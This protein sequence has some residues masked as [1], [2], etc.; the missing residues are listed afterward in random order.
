[1]KYFYQSFLVVG[2]LIFAV[3]PT[4]AQNFWQSVSIPNVNSNVNALVFNAQGHIFVATNGNGIFR[5]TDEG[6]TWAELNTGDTR[7]SFY[8]LGISRNGTL[9]AGSYLGTVLRSTDNGD[10]WTS[11]Q[12]ISTVEG[13]DSSARSIVTSFAFDEEGRVYAAT[14][15]HGIFMSL[16]NGNT[17][18]LLQTNFSY[19]FPMAFDER[20]NLMVGSYGGGIYMSTNR[21]KRWSYTGFSVFLFYQIRIR[22]YVRIGAVDVL[23][24]VIYT[25]S[26][27]G[28]TTIVDSAQQGTSVVGLDTNIT[29]MYSYVYEQLPM[30]V[31][32]FA[33]GTN[34]EVYAGTEAGIF[35]RVGRDTVYHWEEVSH[36]MDKKFVLSLV[37]TSNGD[38][39]AGTFGDGVLR[40]TDNGE[41]WTRVDGAI[42]FPRARTTLALSPSGY[43]Y[44]GTRNGGVY[45]SI[46]PVSASVPLVMQKQETIPSRFTLE[47]GYPNPFNPTVTIPFTLYQPGFVSLKIYNSLGQ[48]VSTL[49]DGAH[50]AGQYRVS[51]DASNYPS[52]VYFYRMQSASDVQVGKLVLTK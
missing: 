29:R 39:Y 22:Q 12:M 51:W 42:N 34:G 37:S 36:K 40:S 26:R 41:N 16:D 32:C 7:K 46:N 27:L 1:M 9:Y 2:C 4:L 17:W 28:D 15:R 21:G 30:R 35:R 33:L 43:L 18:R 24:T 5:S 14:G 48:V 19:P 50:N 13:R 10:N 44:C 8:S 49:I 31:N 52:G 6:S 11:F 45:K 3:A 38:L 20:Q 47:Q 23:D 25:V